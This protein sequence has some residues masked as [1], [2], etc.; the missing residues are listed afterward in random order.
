VI[1]RIHLP[2][3]SE[4]EI[5]LWAA[6][7]GAVIGFAIATLVFGAR[8]ERLERELAVLRPDPFGSHD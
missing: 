1:R 6:L 7:V 3:T 4:P 5:T 2:R 8:A